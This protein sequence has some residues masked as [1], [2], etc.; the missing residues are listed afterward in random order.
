MD[1]DFAIAVLM[2]N[3]DLARRLAAE[4]GTSAGG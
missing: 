1:L 3:R 2:G 4:A